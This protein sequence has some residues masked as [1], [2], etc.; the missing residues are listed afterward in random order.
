[1]YMKIIYRKYVLYTLFYV[2][3]KLLYIY[4]YLVRNGVLI[5]SGKKGSER[6]HVAYF[7]RNRG[8][9]NSVKKGKIAQSCCTA[10]ISIN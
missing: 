7:L 1:M 10:E 2:V 8:V 9:I 5:L 4:Y 3:H 6:N